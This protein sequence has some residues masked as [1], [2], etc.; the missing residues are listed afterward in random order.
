VFTRVVALMVGALVLAGCSDDD[1]AAP[2]PTP[3]TTS[4]ELCDLVTPRLLEEHFAATFEDGEPNGTDT[5]FDHIQ[6]SAGC[7][8]GGTTPGRFGNPIDVSVSVG[9]NA[10]SDDPLGDYFVGYDPIDGLGDMAGFG[11]R[12]SG[13]YDVLLVVTR[14]DGKDRYL[15]V[16]ANPLLD[17]TV[18]QARPIAELVLRELDA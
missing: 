18:D 12:P 14:L 3:G 8:V 16:L 5:S 4:E 1:R 17:A 13:I 10:H 9:L 2:P 6:G 11:P 7:Y 15:E